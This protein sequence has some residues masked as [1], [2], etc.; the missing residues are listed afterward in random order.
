MAVT[1]RTDPAPAPLW[2]TSSGDGPGP[3]RWNWR[4]AL[5]TIGVLALVAV[6]ASF[7]GRGANDPRIANPEVSGAPRPVPPLFGWDHWVL[8]NEIG[9]VVMMAVL[10]TVVVVM[11]RR[12]P[13]HPV[14]LMTLVTTAIVWQDPIMNWTP[15]AAYNPQLW[16]WP[17]HWPLVSL[18]PTVE[19]FIVIGY[20]TFYLGPY[21]PAI[22]LLRRIQARRPHDSFVWRHPLL[23]LA[24]LALVI[25]FVFD[26]ILECFLVRT[27]LYIYT[28]VIP[29]GSLFT[30]KPYQFPLIWESVMVT[31]V[32]V[33]AAVLLYRDDTGR[34]V[35][36]KLA[37]RVRIF[38]GR[39]ALGAFAVMF[40][41]IN[42]AY[43]C[44]GAGFALIRDTRI[45]TS[46]ACPWPYPEAKVY[47]PQGFY[48]KN[49]QAGPYSAGIW[50][51]WESAQSGRPDVSPPADG[52][53]CGGT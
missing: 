15:Y 19:P 53:R 24:G 52:G 5:G 22:W 30:G 10:V 14:L 31:F 32:M 51:G 13:A 3:R 26:A 7:A 25:G 11:W 43:F 28:Q 45:A 1:D 2:E 17:T 33:P 21:F 38:R 34:T 20:A 39:P 40:V 8:V 47:D 50:S 42:I 36:E 16:H 4:V 48:E 12:Y 35:A 37:H 44:Y 6:I 27:Q 29:W 46:V 18:S 9:T 49:G 41:L 23:S